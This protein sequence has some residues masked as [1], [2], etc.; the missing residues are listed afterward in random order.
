MCAEWLSFCITETNDIQPKPY[1]NVVPSGSYIY[2]ACMKERLMQ[3]STY[4]FIICENKLCC[5]WQSSSSNSRKISI[6]K[7]AFFASFTKGLNFA[8]WYGLQGEDKMLAS[9]VP[10]FLFPF[11]FPSSSSPYFLPSFLTL[12]AIVPLSPHILSYFV[13]PMEI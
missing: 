7:S 12:S 2:R 10:S 3:G 8:S 9:F 4:I 11:F 6:I 1:Q 5:K 13:F